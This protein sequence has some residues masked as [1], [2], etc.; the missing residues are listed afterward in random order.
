MSSFHSGAPIQTMPDR[1]PEPW[2]NEIDGIAVIRRALALREKGL[3][4]F[5]IAVVMETYHGVT[6]T[7]STWRHRCRTHGAESRPRGRVP[8]TAMRL[9][10]K[11]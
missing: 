4:Y 5:A 8:E 11:G 9:R 7:D 2:A 10:T 3:S 1:S 6:A